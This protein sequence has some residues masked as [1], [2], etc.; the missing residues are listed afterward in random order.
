M[1]RRPK[2]FG[3]GVE[4]L[5]LAI[6]GDTMITRPLSTYN[7]EKYL[8]LIEIFR[9]N[10]VTYTN[11]EMLL[12]SYTSIPLKADHIGT[13]MRAHPSIAK[14]L[15]WA[16]FNL[17]SCANFNVVINVNIRA[18]SVSSD[19]AFLVPSPQEFGKYVLSKR[20][21]LSEFLGKG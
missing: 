17:V 18:M 16:G 20:L 2:K 14:E 1:K 6:T 5:S 21:K 19:S 8:A 13:Y 11:F 10:D 4:S 7:E 9:N 12:H 15:R 3:S